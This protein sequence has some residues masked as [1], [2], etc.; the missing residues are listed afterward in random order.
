VTIY[1]ALTDRELSA[2][3]DGLRLAAHLVEPE[4]LDVDSLQSLYDVLLH[5]PDAPT[6]AIEALGFAF[7]QVLLEHDWLEWGVQQDAAFGDEISIVV[8]NRQLGCAPLSMIRSRLEDREA[9][10][11]ASLR[12]QTVARLRQLGQFAGSA[13]EGRK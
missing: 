12:D 6:Q 5:D 2:I 11:L 3:A 1:R 13:A 8:A 9:W 4:P 7:G 10:N